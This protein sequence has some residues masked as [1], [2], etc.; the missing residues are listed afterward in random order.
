MLELPEAHTL[1]TQLRATV[2]GRIITGVVVDASPH[3]LAFFSGPP[4][5]Y[6]D[7]LTDAPIIEARALGGMVELVAGELGL[8]L[9]DG[10]A[11]RLFDPGEPLPAKHQLALRLDDGATLVCSIQ[12]YGGIR[13]GPAGDLD[14]PY[15]RI[16]RDRPSPLTSRFDRRY[17][18]ELFAGLKPSLT[19]KAFLATEQRVP[20]L[21]N[22]VLQDILFGAGLNPRS[23]LSALAEDDRLRLFESVKGTLGAMV[24]GGGRDTEK[25]LH[26]ERGG[27]QTILSARTLEQPCRGCGGTITR[28][29][30][31]GGNVY[32]CAT[33]QPLRT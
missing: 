30:F 22:G 33:C 26:G 19:L 24:A 31:L 12:M 18:D 29:A 14:D 20:G 5:A 3:K 23:R 16:A 2:L 8:V 9:G 32:F 6:P 25:D 21:G 17:F 15:Y 11:L 13:L 10:V 7:L 28:Q 27:Y 1:A 4:Q